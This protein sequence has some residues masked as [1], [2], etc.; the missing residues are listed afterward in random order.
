MK[1]FVPS[2]YN[3]FKCIGSECSDTCCV[4]WEVV[5]DDESAEFYRNVKGDFGKRLESNMVI[6]EDDETVF[7]LRNGKCPFLNEKNLCDVYTELGEDKLCTTCTEFPR[8][9]ERFGDLREV[10]LSFSCPEVAR[11]ILGDES[12]ITFS[13]SY[14]KEDIEEDT[15]KDTEKDKEDIDPEFLMELIESRETAINIL[16]K[17]NMKI[18][19]RILLLLSFARDIQ[20]KID[21]NKFEEIALIRQN[22]M[23]EDF[24]VRI[25]ESFNEYSG[26][27]WASYENIMEYIEVYLNLENL[28]ES[29]PESI[30]NAIKVN[31]E[32]N[33]FGTY[34]K[35][36]SRFDE[37][38]AENEYE[39]E[40]LMVYFMFRYFLK[41]A[42]DD[43]VFTKI[44]FAIVSYLIIKE[45]DI[46]RWIQNEFRFDKKDHEKII[47]M[48]SKE[49]E[50]SLENMD[51]LDEEYKINSG[52][53]FENI[54]TTLV[55]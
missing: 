36:H 14:D 32:N 46:A 22:Y 37:Y 19:K 26:R 55:N 54:V 47:Q 40:H 41:A 18:S 23:Q 51:I 17:R 29:W 21:R 24:L 33:D 44:K 28:R 43:D 3:D 8:H 15:E 27:E 35:F 10:G 38:Y 25:A 52:F 34:K 48:Y 30:E 6:D 50:H 13:V 42:Y 4:G 53:N 31:F 16:Q 39:F 11:I 45:L 9:T 2:Y 20:E 12:P 1:T 49:V 5:V 7:V